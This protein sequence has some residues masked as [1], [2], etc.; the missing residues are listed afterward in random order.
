MNTKIIITE[1]Q[2]V[3]QSSERLALGK[4]STQWI[5]SKPLEKMPVEYK[6]I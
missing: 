6:G 1:K 4:A 2:N 5:T 3:E